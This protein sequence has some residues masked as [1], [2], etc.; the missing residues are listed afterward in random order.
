MDFKIGEWITLEDET[1]QVKLGTSGQDL[2]IE[3]KRIT[4]GTVK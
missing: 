3:A 1:T 2:E 4:K